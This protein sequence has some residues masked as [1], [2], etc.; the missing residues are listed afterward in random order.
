MIENFRISSY[1]LWVALKFGIVAYLAQKWKKIEFHR[2]FA[3]LMAMY[4]W[5]TIGVTMAAMLVV[6]RFIKYV[7]DVKA[8]EAEGR[9]VGGSSFP[10]S[11]KTRIPGGTCMYKSSSSADQ[12]STLV[13]TTKKKDKKKKF[14]AR[15]NRGSNNRR[16]AQTQHNEESRNTNTN[17][18]SQD[19]PPLSS[20]SAHPGLE[21]F[22]LWMDAITSIY[23]SY[24]IAQIGEEDAVTILPRSERGRVKVNIRVTNHLFEDIDVYWINYKGREQLRGAIGSRGSERSEWRVQTW[25]GH[26]WAFR[27]RRDQQLLFHFVPFRVL[28]ITYEEAMAEDENKKDSK[29]GLYEFSILEADVSSKDACTISDNAIPYPSTKI[30]SV[31]QAL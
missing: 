5:D 18:I 19:P 6:H 15:G 10:D 13:T 22:H 31:N 7:Q 24:S 12:K 11:G 26:P 2:S 14:T 30:A 3:V 25:V 29:T 1:D 27:R 21:G 28:P 23:R 8:Y 20:S 9:V 4:K 17:T 16:I